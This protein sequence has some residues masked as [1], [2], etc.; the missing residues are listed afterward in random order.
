MAAGI[1][2]DLATTLI[3]ATDKPVL[4]VPAKNVR[5][6]EHSATQRNADWLRRQAVS[7]RT[8]DEGADG[9]VADRRR[10]A[11][12]AVHPRA[13]SAGARSRPRLPELGALR[14]R[15]LPPLRVLL[16]EYA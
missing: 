5:M 8:P 7:R 15:S 13:D 3:L 6:W 2:D 14:L 11:R 12:T 10:H 9:L 16:G 1:A 4:T